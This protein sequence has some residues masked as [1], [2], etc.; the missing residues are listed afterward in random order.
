MGLSMPHETP[1]AA[2]RPV[3]VPLSAAQLAQ[4]NR[5]TT[6]A[7]F[8]SGMAHELNNSLQVMGGLVELLA[9]RTDLPGDAAVRIQKIGGQ[10]DKASAVIRQVLAYVRD[11]PGEP[12]VFDLAT[13]T[14]RAL[15][16]RRYQL[17]RSA[18]TVDW[19]PT[20]EPF[21]VMGDERHIQQVVIN[22]LVNAEEALT[23]QPERQL[24]LTLGRAGGRV[25]L[26]VADSGPGVPA[27][28]REQIFEPFF[29]TRSSPRAVGL[30]LTV[31]AAVAAAHGGR[32]YLAD[33]RPGA[34]FILELPER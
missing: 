15:A 22:L 3:P 31:G 34:T 18:V 27:D 12:I 14:E 28:L 30:G 1:T 29:T 25:Q 9:D 2:D 13:A 21:R 17:G 11:S 16:L 24:R 33:T 7:R 8:V 19:Q 10:T 5:L 6:I 32:L 23:G 26:A 20:G 4:I